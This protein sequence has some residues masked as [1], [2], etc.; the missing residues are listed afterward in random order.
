MP[1]QAASVAR[2]YEGLIDAFVADET[3][4]GSLVGSS[5]KVV[6]TQTL[7]SSLADRERL[8]RTVLG[9]ADAIASA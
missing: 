8:A 5:A 1:A 9:V 4:A 3:D 2:L 6:F 7:M